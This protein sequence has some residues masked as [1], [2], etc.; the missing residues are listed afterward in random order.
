[1]TANGVTIR[2]AV[3]ALGRVSLVADTKSA[4]D[5]AA[6][7]AR[8]GGHHVCQRKQETGGWELRARRRRRGRE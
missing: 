2:Q 7:I 5:Y 1:M 4:A 8:E 6:K 3:E